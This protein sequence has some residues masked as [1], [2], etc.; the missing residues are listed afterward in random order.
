MGEIGLQQSLD[1]LRRILGLEVVI[2]LL[3]DI[4]IRSKAAAGDGVTV[5]AV[6]PGTILTPKLEAAFRRMADANGWADGKAA[7]PEVER[8]V[9]PHVVQVPLGK[10]GSAGDIAHAVAFLCSPLAGYITGVNL[11]VD[12]GVLPTL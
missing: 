12:G 6:S 1:G 7:W 8:A 10:V 3:P 11:R 5:N 2:D 9:L 4:G